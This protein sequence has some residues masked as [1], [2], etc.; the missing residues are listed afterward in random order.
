MSLSI[1]I[2]VLN[3]AAGIVSM[4]SRL[5]SLRRQGAQVIV[6]DGGSVDATVEL[7]RPLADLVLASPPGRALQMNAGAS[8]ASGAALLFLHADTALPEGALQAI[9][10][11]LADRLWGRFDV[12]LDGRHPMLP[13]I[14]AMMNLRSRMTGIATGDQAIFMRRTSFDSLGGFTVMP[15]MEDIDFCR[16][17]KRL[18]APACLRQRVHTSGRRWERHGVWRTV[19]LMWQLRLAYFLGADPKRL[20]LKYG[21]GP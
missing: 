15:L 13:L 10:A 11:V 1:V 18:G 3:E 4:L 17:A 21:Y 5:A 9:D 16:R 7:A 14:A 20:A 6:V 8:A 19:L 12:A 2:P